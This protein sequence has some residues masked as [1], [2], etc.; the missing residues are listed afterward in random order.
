MKLLQALEIVALS[1]V[2]LT[3]WRANGQIFVSSFD[4]GTV[5]EYGTDGTPVNAGLISGLINPAALALDGGNLFVSVG[6]GVGKYTISGTVINASLIT[7]FWASGL[8]SDGKGTLYVVD[9]DNNKIRKYTTSGTLLNPSLVTGLNDP[10][11][12]A[13]DGNGYLYVANWSSPNGHGTIG[14]YTTNGVPVNATL[15]STA[16]GL[17]QPTGL[18][19]D[20]QGIFM[21]RMQTETVTVR[22]VRSAS[23]R[24]TEQPLTPR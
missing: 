11:A 1:V 12:I 20:G 21:W 6:E 23:S 24:P 16:A 13:L 22:A 2:T 14:K 7:G 17:A 4:D 8:A 15:I 18:A 5:G 10:Q 3:T 9:E 19:V